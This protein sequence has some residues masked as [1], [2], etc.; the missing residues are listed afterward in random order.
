[1]T[2]GELQERLLQDDYDMVRELAGMNYGPHNIA[3]KLDIDK[4]AFL[5]LWRVKDSQLREA[6]RNGLQDLQDM[7][8]EALILKL[9]EG[10]T[11]AIEIVEKNE[12]AKKFE[13]IKQDVFGI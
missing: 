6:Y 9:Q 3:R 5:R 13:A 2:G 11:R 7:K 1:M 10:S 4:A 8:D 12:E